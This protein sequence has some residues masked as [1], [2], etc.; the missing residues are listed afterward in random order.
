MDENDNINFFKK[1]YLL[2]INLTLLII[3][4][5][6]DITYTQKLKN[7]QKSIENKWLKIFC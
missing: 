2:Y 6:N 1:L 3:M 7:T 4:M 5:T